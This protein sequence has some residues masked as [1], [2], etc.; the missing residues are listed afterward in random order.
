MAYSRLMAEDEGGTSRT[1][2]A[3]RATMAELVAEHGGRILGGAGDSVI[4][5][6]ASPVKSVRTAVPSSGRYGAAM[7]TCRPSDE[8]SSASA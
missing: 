5:E 3:Y 1:L 4:A 6:F 8:W 2:E 7:P